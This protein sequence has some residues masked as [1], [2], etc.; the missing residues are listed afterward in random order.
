MTIPGLTQHASLLVFALLAVVGLVV[1]IARFKV[2]SFVALILAALFVGLTSGMD[3]VEIGTVFHNGVGKILGGIAMIVGLG[4]LLGKML[5]ES[6]GSEV[7]AQTLIRTLGERRL[8]WAMMLVAFLVGTPV[9]FTVGL[10]LLVPILFTVARQTRTPLLVLG[11]PLGAGLSVTH[12]LVPPHPGPMVAIGLLKADVG[13]TILYSLIVGLPTAIVGGP[14][15][16]RWLAARHE[17]ALDGGP[18]SQLVSK[19]GR[20]NLPGFGLTLVTILLPVALMLAATAAGVTLPKENPLRRWL[21]FFGH[22]LVAMTVAFLFSCWSFGFARGFNREQILK[23]SN[24]CVGSVASMLLI[25]GAGGGFSGVLL[26]SGVGDAIAALVK[27]LPVSPLVLGW[28]A[29]A[30]IRV[31]TGSATVAITTAAG[32]LA[33]IVAGKSGTNLELLVLSMGAGSLVLSHVNDGGFWFVKEYFNLSVPQMLKT[34]TVMVTVISVVALV[35]VL[36]LDAGL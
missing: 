28:L 9:W 26:A 13:L 34:W 24:D 30:L 19:T 16:A 17:V 14:M 1:L 15:C 3:L 32:I 2:N 29:A 27:D 18:A 11:L 36:A 6:G 35:L 20:E 21:D 8:T 25:V 33:P 5:A 7:V 12:C 22:P 4:T 10:V 23:F 31:A